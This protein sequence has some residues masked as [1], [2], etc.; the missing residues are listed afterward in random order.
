MR[1]LSLPAALNVTARR[2]ALGVK[3]TKQRR[4]IR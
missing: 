4:S 2:A 3:D 1:H